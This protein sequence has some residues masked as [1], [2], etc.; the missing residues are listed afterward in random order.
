MLSRLI[1]LDLPIEV[2]ADHVVGADFGG[3]LEVLVESYFFCL[4]KAF[5]SHL[6]SEANMGSVVIFSEILRKCQ[7]LLAP[8]KP[9]QC[10]LYWSISLLTVHLLEL[11]LECIG[12]TEDRKFSDLNRILLD[13]LCKTRD[14]PLVIPCLL[15]GT[16]LHTMR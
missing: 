4:G 6:D 14:I 15:D 3:E 10:Y 9:E 13:F 7:S 16:L 11:R 12:P 8:K 5:R 2:E 1:S